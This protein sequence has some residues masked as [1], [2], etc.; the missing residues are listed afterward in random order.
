MAIPDIILHKPSGLDENEWEV[1]KEHP[2]HAYEMLKSIEFLAPALD[3]PLYH[4]EQW[5][6]QGYPN[7]LVGDQIPLAARIFSVV[8][9]WDALLSIRPYRS[10]WNR[11]QVTEYLKSESG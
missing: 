8:D 7:G 9:N 2:G 3:I 5:D 11:Q 4:H 6:G 1:V 10:A